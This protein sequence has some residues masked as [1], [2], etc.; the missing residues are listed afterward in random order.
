MARKADV[1]LSRGRIETNR[2]SMTATAKSTTTTT[3]LFSVKQV[4]V[5]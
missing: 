4:K 2:F 5:S 3:M 1:I